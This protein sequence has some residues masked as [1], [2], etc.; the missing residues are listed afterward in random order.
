MR[1]LYSIKHDVT[2][3]YGWVEEYFHAFLISALDGDEKSA[4]RPGRSDPG[5]SPQFIE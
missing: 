4:S 2:K 1:I 5:R 3:T